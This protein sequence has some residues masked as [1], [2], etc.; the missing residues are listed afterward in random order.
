VIHGNATATK[1]PA[2]NRALR[3]TVR[4]FAT[5][6]LSLLLLRW[7]YA[8]RTGNAVVDVIPD[9]VWNAYHRVIGLDLEGGVETIQN[10][11]ALLVL[12]C[13]TIVAAVIVALIERLSTLHRRR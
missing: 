12:G 7:A 3:W 4:V 1:T 13:T 8:T 2:T 11:D 10:Y 5:V 6:A 9:G